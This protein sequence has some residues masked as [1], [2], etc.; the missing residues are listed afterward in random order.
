MSHEFLLHPN[1]SANRVNPHPVRM[2]ECVSA[3][4][5]G[6]QQ[7][8]VAAIAQKMIQTTRGFLIDFAIC[9]L[10]VPHDVA[11]FRSRQPSRKAGSSV[12]KSVD[13]PEK[14]SDEA[15]T[16]NEIYYDSPPKVR[17]FLNAGDHT[18]I[19][20]IRFSG[21]RRNHSRQKQDSA[22]N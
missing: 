20:S 14:I 15:K 16:A 11:N 21:K 7:A 4:G 6:P 8:N 9:R 2:A 18:N 12:C 19:P 10:Q 3:Q 13:L 5:E 1:R 22:N 17:R